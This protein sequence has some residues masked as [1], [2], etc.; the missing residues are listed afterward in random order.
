MK[1]SKSFPIL[2][3]RLKERF[4]ENPNHK[5]WL[6]GIVLCRPQLKLAREEIIPSLSFFHRESGK[7]ID[8]F[9][10]G[11]DEK[12]ADDSDNVPIKTGISSRPDWNFNLDEFGRFAD[13]IR[14]K[15]DNRYRYTGGCD[16]ILVNCLHS[17]TG[18]AWLDFNDSA[19]ASLEILRNQ[20]RLPDT[21]HFFKNIFDYCKAVNATD[22][23][24]GFGVDAEPGS[25]LVELCEKFLKHAN[26]AQTISSVKTTLGESADKDKSPKSKKHG[27]LNK[28]PFR[29]DLGTRNLILKS[30]R[31]QIEVQTRYAEVLDGMLKKQGGQYAVRQ[32]HLDYTTVATLFDLGRLKEDH[33]DWDH[34]KLQSEL[35]RRMDFPDAKLKKI[36]QEFRRQFSDWLRD[37]G[38][39]A[40]YVI[41]ADRNNKGYKLGIGFHSTRAATGDSEAGLKTIGGK[42]E[43]YDADSADNTGK[44]TPTRMG[45]DGEYHDAQSNRQYKMR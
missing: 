40:D 43:G 38:I 14:R 42:I 3:E 34:K 21:S 31:I 30:S 7:N 33:P 29:Y 20:G 41:K 24:W 45:A 6:V 2:L 22:S 19:L 32:S 25:S 10:A 26:T 44:L 17:E 5:L 9:F 12:P 36:A 18:D 16:L 4:K 13:E 1:S 28:G 15:T 39:D 35:R 8:F 37:N 11:F 27:E 23:G